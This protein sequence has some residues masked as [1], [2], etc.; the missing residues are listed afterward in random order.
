TILGRAFLFQGAAANRH[1]ICSVA[2]TRRSAPLEQPCGRH[3]HGNPEVNLRVGSLR[4]DPTP[5]VS[6]YAATSVPASSSGYNGRAR[7]LY[8]YIFQSALVAPGLSHSTSPAEI[9]T[10]TG[11]QYMR[12]FSKR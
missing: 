9:G 3:R 7:R 4:P 6:I 2:H 5:H 8:G 12:D 11:R 1:I 10:K